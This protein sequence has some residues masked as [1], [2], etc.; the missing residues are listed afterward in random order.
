MLKSGQVEQMV[1]RAFREN[2]G[3]MGGGSGFYLVRGYG[4]A[5]NGAQGPQA[6]A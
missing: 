6:R 1:L 5:A 3:G 4:G 2:E